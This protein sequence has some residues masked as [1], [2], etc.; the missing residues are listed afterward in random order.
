MDSMRAMNVTRMRY[1]KNESMCA[2]QISPISINRLP[3]LNLPEWLSGQSVVKLPYGH[4]AVSQHSIGAESQY[5]NQDPRFINIID[6]RK[7]KVVRFIP[8]INNLPR[9]SLRLLAD[10][11]M[12][13]YNLATVNI[14][15]PDTGRLIRTISLQDELLP[16]VSLNGDSI[17]DLKS[18]NV[19]L[20]ADDA[21][22]IQIKNI[23]KNK[24]LAVNCNQNMIFIL[25]IE[26]NRSTHKF[27]I[28]SYKDGNDLP[29]NN[30]IASMRALNNG[31]LIIAHANGVINEYSPDGIHVHTA[32]TNLRDLSSP[33][34]LNLA[35]DFLAE[36]NLLLPIPNFDLSISLTA[37]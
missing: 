33:D 22:G 16:F 2:S 10:G 20:M 32:R 25:D 4:Y 6:A 8:D 27:Q 21:G 14:Y 1:W 28:N 3:L 7:N 13:A 5:E 11:T 37:D 9:R 29:L 15:H 24:K 12:A 30:S 35:Y 17:I 26:S 34:A 36:S 18:D 23:L 19:D 31:H